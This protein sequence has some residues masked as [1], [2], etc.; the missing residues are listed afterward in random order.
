MK[1]F[2][3]LVLSV[4][5][6]AYSQI[7]WAAPVGPWVGN[8]TPAGNLAY[9]ASG[10][11][12]KAQQQMGVGKRWN[13]DLLESSGLGVKVTQSAAL[14]VGAGVANTALAGLIT[15]LGVLATAG[16]I[17]GSPVVAT[18]SA[19]VL[20]PGVLDWLLQVDARPA[21]SSSPKLYEVRDID[22]SVCPAIAPEGSPPVSSNYTNIRWFRTSPGA[23]FNNGQINNTGQ[24]VY[25]YA[26]NFSPDGGATQYPQ[27]NQMATRP[28][29]PPS[30]DWIP[31]DYSDF[32]QRLSGVPVSTA[33]IN[34][35][36]DAGYTF[37]LDGQ[38][39]TGPATV[40]APPVSNSST[41]INNAGD[42][43]TTTNTTNT[44]SNQT[45]NNSPSP[46]V[47]SSTTTTTTTNVHN[48]TTNTNISNTTSTENKPDK[49]PSPEEDLSFSDSSLPELPKLY[50]RSYP[51]G[52]SG[53][54]DEKIAGIKA[55]PLFSLVG[56]L[57]PDLGSTG[58]C[59][60]WPLPLEFASWASFGTH[61]V[62]PPCWVWDFGKTIIIISSLLLARALIFG[63]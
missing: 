34:S 4:F 54:W 62:A 42:S 37:P 49:D 29:Q 44:V 21:S 12:S 52:M 18:V 13:P 45:Y 9:H 58:S 10:A 60:S 27:N 7:V 20:L 19:F 31:A 16:T 11:Y 38:T 50:E 5:A 55:A 59:P 40:S 63:G 46:S 17:L 22:G 43:I 48:N 24:C 32:S 53:V 8:L 30:D 15:P 23:V 2:F 33:L 14:P 61:D 51:D 39:V 26:W 57:M 28:S 41:T 35:L 3:A 6:F 56:K 25:G 47:T 36:L 1:N